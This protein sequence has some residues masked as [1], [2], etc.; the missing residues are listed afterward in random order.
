MP[1]VQFDG[2][3]FYA[4]LDAVR[5]ERKLTWRKVA[6][7][8]GVS[9]SSLTRI[10]Q[11][12]RPDVDSLASL[13]SWAKLSAD[14][15]MR[16]HDSSRNGEPSSLTKALMLFRADPNLGKEQADALERIIQSAYEGLRTH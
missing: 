4:A 14:D 8:S 7:Q 16:A 3:G 2:N 12:K 9:A 6:E 10:S 1:N 13:C 5:E 15:F 11:G